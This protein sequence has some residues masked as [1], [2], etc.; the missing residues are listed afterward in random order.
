MT[1]RILNI[2]CDRIRMKSWKVQSN[3]NLCKF[4]NIKGHIAT[5]QEPANSA[6]L[7]KGKG[8]ILF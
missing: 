5:C 6:I 8:A 4:V 1:A 7:L 3:V 2:P